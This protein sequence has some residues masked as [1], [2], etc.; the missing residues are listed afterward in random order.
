ST[1]ITVRLVTGWGLV[2]RGECGLVWDGCIGMR[3][4]PLQYRFDK[5]SVISAI[6]YQDHLCICFPI[7]R[8][9]KRPISTNLGYF[10]RPFHLSAPPIIHLET[11]ALQKLL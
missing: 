1:S 6:E 2:R 7:R 9:V 8:N 5:F 10:I 3:I 11:Y 4:L